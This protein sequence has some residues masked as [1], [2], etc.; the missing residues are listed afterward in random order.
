MKRGFASSAE[1]RRA[2]IFR[3]DEVERATAGSEAILHLATAIPTRAPTSREDWLLNDRLRL[4]G[5]ESL[6]E[7]AALGGARLYLQQSVTF[8]YGDREGAWVDED[9]PIAARLAPILESARDMEAIV[10][11]ARVPAV[12][13]RLGSFY[14]FDAAHTRLRFEAARG[15]ESVVIAGGRNYT[16]SIHV[17]DAAGAVCLAVEAGD[18]LAGE[19]FNVC[20]D[21]PA[22]ARAI[23][24]FTSELNAR[25]ARSIPLRSRSDL[26]S[27][28]I[29][30][31]PLPS[32][33]AIGRRT[34]GWDSPRAIRLSGKDT[35]PRLRSGAN[36][37]R[38][39]R[40]R[41]KIPAFGGS[42]TRTVFTWLLLASV[43]FAQGRPTSAANGRS[44]RTER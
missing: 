33:A 8:L 43:S 32:A 35:G 24:D 26:G 9:T 44:T 41:A 1:P 6:V 22:T 29:D 14:A 17:D 20:D 4:E 18:F 37:F 11:S 7:A 3:P 36:R 2:D 40:T 5:T 15:N 31:P 25:K 30:P 27:H 12:I 34:N 38:R 16:N 19:T 42:M 10:R 21:E 28:I 39:E 23:A 13:L